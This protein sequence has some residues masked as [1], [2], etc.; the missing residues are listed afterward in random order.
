MNLAELT[1]QLTQMAAKSPNALGGSSLKFSFPEGVVMI[2][3][4]GKVS[5]EDKEADC[6][7]STSLSDLQK[8]IS[9]DLNPMSAVMFGKIKIKGDM[10]V[11]MKLQSLMG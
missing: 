2:D 6:T 11:A 10:S 4:S 9:G 1:T 3:E 7:I 5:N 8:I